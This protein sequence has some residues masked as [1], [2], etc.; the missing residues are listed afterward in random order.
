[1]STPNPLN[2]IQTDVTAVVA[3]YKKFSTYALLG[4]G[5]VLGFIVK[6]LL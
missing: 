2:T 4:A 5:F 6:A 1:M 3:W